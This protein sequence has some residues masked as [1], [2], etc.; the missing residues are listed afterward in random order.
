MW[1]VHGANVGCNVCVCVCMYACSSIGL[2]ENAALKQGN[3]T[4]WHSHRKL[5]AAQHCE[6]VKTCRSIESL[7]LIGGMAASKLIIELIAHKYIV[8]SCRIELCDILASWHD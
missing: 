1:W 7:I 4:I 8:Q 6:V 3:S 2:P 5:L